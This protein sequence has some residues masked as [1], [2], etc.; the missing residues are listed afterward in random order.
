[1]LAGVGDRV[2]GE[3][4]EIGRV[5]YHLRR[6]LSADENAIVGPAIDCRG[7]A[8][9]WER[10]FEVAAAEVP[11]CREQFRQFAEQEKR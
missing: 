6:R 2:R 7:L 1:M 11:Y 10:R 3:W 8:D 5:A 9:E 4:I